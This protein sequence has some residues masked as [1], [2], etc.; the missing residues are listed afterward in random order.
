MSKRHSPRPTFKHFSPVKLEDGQ[1]LTRRD[2]QFDLLSH[3]MNNTSAVFTDPFASPNAD[4]VC[5]RDL[6]V[7][8]IISSGK[9]S[10]VVRDKLR[11][12]PQFATD[13]AMLSLLANVGRITSGMA[14]TLMF[15]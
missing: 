9:V 10:Q 3:L 14:C 8:A 5:F 1:Q 4:R 12:V 2:L 6:Y 13:F 7:N 15:H 11:D